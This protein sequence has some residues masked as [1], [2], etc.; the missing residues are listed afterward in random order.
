MPASSLP[1]APLVSAIVPTYNRLPYLREAVASV[2]AQ[3]YDNW[4]LIV[5][6]DGS[7]DGTAAYLAG[8]G[9]QRVRVVRVDHCA[10]PARVRNLGVGR[11]NGFYLAFLDSDDLWRPSKLE[12]QVAALA[13]VPGRRW[14]CTGFALVDE[15]GVALRPAGGEPVVLEG[16][17]LR[18]LVTTHA[19][20]AISS[21]VVERGFLME[22]GLFDESHRVAFREDYDLCLRLALHGPVVAIAEALCLIRDH[23]DRSTA[24]LRDVFERSAAVYENFRRL[25]EDRSVRRLCDR[26][27]AHHYVAA[28]TRDLRAGCRRTAARSLVRALA[29][30]PVCWRGWKTVIRCVL[31]RSLAYRAADPRAAVAKL[32]IEVE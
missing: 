24:V 27:R 32:P 30:H 26:Q 23:A 13:R 1:S 4:E 12:R 16:D 17:I 25:I 22:V 3:T 9:D 10:N 14:C 15:A 18:S 11:A 6:D 7:T 2:F 19:A 5:V 31:P 8:L 20:V 21:I 28:A 29:V